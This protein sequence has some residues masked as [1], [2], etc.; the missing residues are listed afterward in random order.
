MKLDVKADLPQEQAA[1]PSVEAGLAQLGWP[2]DELLDALPSLTW[3]LDEQLNARFA[4][5]ALLRYAGLSWPELQG[6]GWQALVHPHDW[7]GFEQACRQ[8]LNS[9]PTQAQAQTPTP[10]LARDYRLRAADGSYRWQLLQASALP[11][12]SAQ[13]ETLLLGLH[14]DIDERKR[15]ESQLQD[16]DDLWKL[17][18]ESNGDGVW[19]WYVQ[20]G[21]ELYSS[22]YLQIYGYAESDVRPT[23]AEFD[24]RTH[25][26]DLAQ[27]QADRDAHFCGHTGSYSNE[28]RVLC[29]DGNWKWIHSRGMVISRDAQG[30]P[31]RMVGT[32]TD[33]TQRKAA[34]ALIWQQAHFDPLTG[35]PNRRSLRERLELGLSEARQQAGALALLFID[36]DH[37]KEVNDTLGHD[38]GDR[39]LI[40]AGARIQACLRPG[41]TVARMGGDEFTVLLRADAAAPQIETTARETAL[42][43]IAALSTAFHLA[44]ERVFVSAS[45]GISHFPQD[46]QEI[47]S[48]FKHADQALYAAKAAGRNRLGYFTPELQQAALLRMRLSNDL[49]EALARQ[50][51]FVEYQAIVDLRSGEVHKAEALLRWQHP[52]QGVIGPAVFI[53]L[54]EASGLILE[55]GAWVFGQAAQQV[56]LWRQHFDATFQISVNKSPVQFRSEADTAP[57]SE[58][59]AEVLRMLELAGEALT[60]EI[61]EGLLL[62]AD[63]EVESHL[64]A[65]HA[66]GFQVSLDD[67][68]TGF[69]SLAYL[70]KYA[71]DLLKID[72]RFVRNLRA[73]AKDLA[74]CTAI[75]TMAHALGMKVVAEGVETAEQADLLLAAGCDYAQG[76]LFGRPMPA[77]DFEQLFGKD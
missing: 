17:A 36:L 54:A 12:N 23:P 69:S 9:Q 6:L 53:P 70:Q 50:Q 26:D 62:E 75:I 41:D 29:K 18:L 33:I 16:A 61:T 8:Y 47:E 74:L 19:D 60:I 32:H 51:L 15:V 76:Y 11:A 20:S 39:L 65:L 64:A 71:I 5:T 21:V 45:I 22:R 27:M 38:M 66:A 40:E 10:A 7:P 52:S 3:V 63:S 57:A 1:M 55:I 44:T 59:W 14:S 72:Q 68:G 49:R 58:S 31:L 34:E 35:L 73:G 28:H 30:R 48:L 46:G 56:K 42:Q 2:A 24:A 4:S 43:I 77:E 67:F 13:S 37:F 25:P